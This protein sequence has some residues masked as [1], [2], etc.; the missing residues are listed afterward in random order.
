MF[1]L[2]KREFVVK[3]TGHFLESKLR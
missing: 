3:P 1:G 2:Q